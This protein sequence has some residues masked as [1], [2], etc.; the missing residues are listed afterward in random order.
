MAAGDALHPEQFP[1]HKPKTDRVMAYRYPNAGVTFCPTCHRQEMKRAPL[2]PGEERP[3]VVRASDYENGD[4]DICSGGC[5]K[6]IKGAK[7]MRWD[8]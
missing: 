8:A 3:K 6:T 2:E 5:G 4:L 1:A 7:E